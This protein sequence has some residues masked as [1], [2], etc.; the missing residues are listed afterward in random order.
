MSYVHLDDIRKLCQGLDRI[1]KSQGYVFRVRWRKHNAGLHRQG[2]EH[3]NRSSRGQDSSFTAQRRAPRRFEFQGEIFE[4]WIDPTASPPPPSASAAQEKDSSAANDYAW[5]EVTGVLSN[6]Q[7][8]LAIRPLERWEILEQQE[9]A[10]ESS[11]ITA[12]R[13]SCTEFGQRGADASNLKT[14]TDWKSKS[15]RM[16]L[17]EAMKMPGQQNVSGL[18][19]LTMTS[20]PDAIHLKMPGALPDNN[21]NK[22]VSIDVNTSEYTKRFLQPQSQRHPSLFSD[23]LFHSDP[24]ECAGMKI[25]SIIEFSSTAIVSWTE[26]TVVGLNAWHHWT[27]TVRAGQDHVRFW[28]EYILE[29]AIDQT[30]ELVSWGLTLV[31]V[32]C[33]SVDSEL[34][35]QRLSAA[36]A[37]KRIRSSK[38]CEQKDCLVYGGHQHQYQ[39]QQQGLGH[40]SKDYQRKMSGLDRASKKILEGY[41]SLDGIV[42]NFGN[43]WLGKKIKSRLDYR[44]DIVADKM[45]DWWESNNDESSI[46]S[47]SP[48]S[49]SSSSSSPS[50]SPSSPPSSPSSSS[51][52]ALSGGAIVE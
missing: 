8:M 15:K 35:E 22:N 46:L 10:S 3:D 38:S 9:F 11:M 6:G 44:L 26:L 37:T 45:M 33:N 27:R 48:P 28:C 29:S 20:T 40:A 39:R 47:E 51:S 50:S 34:E 42:R 25:A 2:H 31:G 7:P 19:T 4:E 1:C 52:S 12:S 14:R 36:A 43:S 24:E 49:S 13:R 5:T 17:D 16:E 18:T 41:P 32:D 21:N 30:I 23:P